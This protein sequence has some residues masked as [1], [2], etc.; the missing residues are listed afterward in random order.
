MS[1]VALNLA[2]PEYEQQPEP[3]A[4]AGLL[5]R[6]KRHL[7]TGPPE[8]AKTILA[9]A[10]AQIHKRER[11][12]AGIKTVVAHIDFEM[13]PHA[14]RAL[15]VDLGWTLQEIQD[16]YYVQPDR[17]PTETDLGNIRGEG[18][19]LV[20]ID[21][22]AGAYG[23]AGLDDSKRGDV[24]SFAGSWID[25]LYAQGIATILNDHVVKDD[26]QR[27][28]WAIGS[29][30]K[31]GACDVAYGL[32]TIK[33]L[34][35]GG[36]GLVKVRVNKDRP[37]FLTRPYATTL[38]LTSHPDTHA[39][40][41]QWQ[42]PGNQHAGERWL[43][44]VLMQRVSEYLAQQ[45]EGASRNA[46]EK[47]VHG[48]SNEH[49]RQAID[50]LV[51]LGNAVEH[52]GP[53]GARMVTLARPFTSPDIALNSPGEDNHDLAHLARPLQGGEVAGEDEQ[54]ATSLLNQHELE[55]LTIRKH[56][57]DEDWR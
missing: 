9:W 56:G 15:L 45:P 36:H 49:K 50:E 24:E 14:T 51:A 41:W 39:I 35:R 31:M 30:R 47:A 20:L 17:P 27:G 1:W 16:I 22:A 2:S 29:E 25:P 44:T 53:R 52:H 38:A 46:I 55:A 3:P 4:W 18:I 5:Y 34:T 11:E 43:P 26:K 48:K 42:A 54:T 23:V 21:A 6:G 10:L 40:S 37:G 7:V 32:E 13:G 8:S 57:K 12:A 33:T 19:E 28:R